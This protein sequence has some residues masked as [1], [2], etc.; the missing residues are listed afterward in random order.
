MIENE[1][2]PGARSDP[3]R[4]PP[5]GGWIGLPRQPIGIP[6]GSR[7]QDGVIKPAAEKRKIEGE[8]SRREIMGRVRGA[9]FRRNRT[10]M[11]GEISV[12]VLVEE[13]DLTARQI[14][15]RIVPVAHQYRFNN[16]TLGWILSRTPGII[17]I[18]SSPTSI[19]SYSVEAG[20]IPDL[21]QKTKQRLH[22]HLQKFNPPMGD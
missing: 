18:K 15:E 22:D 19:G 1:N 11:I 9:A 17:K 7:R 14:A 10:Y 16:A 8:V 21:P 12:A 20:R 2:N 13:P 5:F 6:L 3:A 4:P